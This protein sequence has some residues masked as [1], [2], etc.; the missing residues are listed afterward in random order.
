M[1][2]PWIFWP[3][4]LAMAAALSYG[5]GR[6]GKRL[7]ADRGISPREGLWAGALFG[8]SGLVYMCWRVR[9]DRRLAERRTG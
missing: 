3:M 5:F 6:W 2:N 4:V 1:A 9:V 8:P 7:A